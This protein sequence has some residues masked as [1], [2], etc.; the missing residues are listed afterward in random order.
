MPRANKTKDI[1]VRESALNLLRAFGIDTIFGN[2]GSTE[3]PM[4]RAFPN[5]FRYIL[6]LQESI[7]VAMADGYA[8]RTRNAAFVNLHSAAGLG[9]ALGNIFT[10][11]RNATPLIVTAGQQARSILP[12]D[13]FLFA[14]QAAEFPKPYVKWANEPARAADVPQALA[15]ASACAC[16]CGTSAAR[17]RWRAPAPARR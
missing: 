15:R 12:F 13:P 4:F 6:G 16:A 5:D 10:A 14:Q 11:F 2:P 8:Q 1:T 9:H 17:R 7:V 3:L